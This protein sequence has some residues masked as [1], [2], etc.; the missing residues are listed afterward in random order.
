ML[1]QAKLKSK[2]PFSQYD[3]LAREGAEVVWADPTDPSTYPEG[4]FDIV[5]D[6]NG[7][8]L[9]VCKPLIDAFKVRLLVGSCVP[10]H[11]A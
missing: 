11:F 8:T 6:N 7:K 5:Y 4:P 3:D 2:A 1:L 10:C 9:D